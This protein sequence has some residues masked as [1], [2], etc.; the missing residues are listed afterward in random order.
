MSINGVQLVHLM[1]S[2]LF[3]SHAEDDSDKDKED[4]S[5]TAP[6]SPVMATL[7]GD[8]AGRDSSSS[9]AKAMIRSLTEAATIAKWWTSSYGYKASKKPPQYP[10]LDQ[11]LAMVYFPAR[12]CGIY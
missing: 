2:I 9:R 10:S 12:F 3:Y 8:M 5:L 1:V 11:V 6:I 4:K 7:K